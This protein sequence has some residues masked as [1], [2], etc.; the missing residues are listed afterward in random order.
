MAEPYVGLRPPTHTPSLPRQVIFQPYRSIP[1]SFPIAVIPCPS[2][3]FRPGLRR[4]RLPH[5][6]IRPAK[7]DAAD[8]RPQPQHVR[9]AWR[10]G[11]VHVDLENVGSGDEITRLQ[12]PVNDELAGLLRAVAAL[13][14][15][16][17]LRRNA[18]AVEPDRGNAVAA[19]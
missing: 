10:K 5:R 9:R 13:A 4:R 6:S 2:M 3:R 11:V 15:A 16:A 19:T 12:A 7:A 18:L 14:A 17:W 8:F 1:R